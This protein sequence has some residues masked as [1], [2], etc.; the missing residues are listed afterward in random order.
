MTTRKADGIYAHGHRA[1]RA[2]EVGHLETAA[3]SVA[4]AIVAAADR[5]RR[6][7]GGGA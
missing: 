4:A 5:R 6:Q 2:L 1:F 3:Q 7:A